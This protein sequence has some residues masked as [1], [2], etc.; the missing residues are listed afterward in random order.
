MKVPG[1]LM[2]MFWQSP[3][4]S[5]TRQVSNKSF[6]GQGQKSKVAGEAAHRSRHRDLLHTIEPAR[7][8]SARIEQYSL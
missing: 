7:N 2:G 8:E 6:E 4:S 3:G 1:P 5:S